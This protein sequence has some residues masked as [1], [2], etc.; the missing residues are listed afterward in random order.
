MKTHRS[1]LLATVT[2][3]LAMMVFLSGCGNGRAEGRQRRL[4]TFREALPEE[5]RSAFDSIGDSIDCER[6]GGMLAESR[7]TDTGLDARID[8]IMHAELVDAFTDTDLV[9]FFWYHFALAIRTGTI[10]NP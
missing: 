5:V 1:R 9:H 7:A 6:V 2:L 8:S 3:V 4:D 10:P